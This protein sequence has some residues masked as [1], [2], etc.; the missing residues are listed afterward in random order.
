MGAEGGPGA[1]DLVASWEPRLAW[2]RKTERE[3][4][5]QAVL[6]AYE[7]AG[8][9]RPQRILWASGVREAEELLAGTGLHAW[10]PW[11]AAGLTAAAA[12][13][14]ILLSWTLMPPPAVILLGGAAFLLSALILAM[15]PDLHPG[16]FGEGRAHFWRGL[17]LVSIFAF[18]VGPSLAPGSVD[19]ERPAAAIGLLC[20]LSALGLLWYRRVRG[21][22]RHWRARAVNRRIETMLRTTGRGPGAA[23]MDFGPTSRLLGAMHGFRATLPGLLPGWVVPVGLIGWPGRLAMLERHGETG[24]G[25]SRA[26]ACR[27]LAFHVDALF[28][29]DEIAIILAPPV[30]A[31]ID[32]RGRFHNTQGPALRWADGSELFAFEG[33]TPADPRICLE[34]DRLSPARIQM[35][36]DVDLRRL[37][38]E[39]YGPA[40][41]M[42]NGRGRMVAADGTGELWRLDAFD[43][44]P[45]VMVK[46]RNSTQEPD[47]TYRDYWLRV[48]PTVTSPRA[49]VAWTFGLPAADYQ[50]RAET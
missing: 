17:A 8:L 46:V 37:L 44:E 29:F 33:R 45:L 34:P 15:L 11:A 12:A 32:A 27:D 1:Q 39:R 22:L 13:A 25:R 35:E 21:R 7:A 30:E 2:R 47:G 48:P 18:L 26:R 43:G 6:A 14:A 28:A 40:R 24:P 16:G 3:P 38:L 5:E 50:P 49:A 9:P 36:P 42:R 4:A 31:H 41:L 20:F 19:V 23:R 10:L